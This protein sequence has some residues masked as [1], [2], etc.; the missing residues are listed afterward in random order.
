MRQ[1][2]RKKKYAHTHILHDYKKLHNTVLYRKIIL[3]SGIWHYNI[4]MM[5]YMI[6]SP[7]VVSESLIS[8]YYNPGVYI[9]CNFESDLRTNSGLNHT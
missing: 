7:S 3:C 5:G 8:F 2:Q 6:Y 1:K 9:E 4:C